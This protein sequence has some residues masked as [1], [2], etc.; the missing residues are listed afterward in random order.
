MGAEDKRMADK[1]TWTILLYLSTDNSL[2]EEGVYALKE[3]KKVGAKDVN[4]FAQFDPSGRGN[5]TRRFL[6]N[7]YDSTGK[8]KDT[9][10][11]QSLDET[12]M[13][14]PDTLRSFIMAAAIRFPATTNFMLILAGHGGGISEGFFLRDE[15][16][17]LSEIPSAFPLK[18]LKEQ[19]FA[20][21]DVITALGNR[22]I[23][24]LGLDSCMMSM[25]EVCYEIRDCEKL[26]YVVASEGFSLDAGWPYE[27]LVS[28]IKDDNNIEPLALAKAIVQEHAAFYADYHLGGLSTDLSVVKL[29]GIADL[30]KKIGDLAEALSK[31]FYA[32]IDLED[33]GPDGTEVLT[34]DLRDRKKEER[35][36]YKLDGRPF[37][38][39]IILAHWAAQSYN[40][41]QSIDLNDFCLM[42]QKRSHYFE[43]KEAPDSIYKRCEAVQRAI[44]NAVAITCD[45]GAAF[46]FSQGVSISLP[47]SR[48][49]LPP[50]YPT[51]RFSREVPGWLKF[52]ADYADA[53]QRLP[54]ARPH[55][56]E[57]RSTPPYSRGPEGRTLSMRNPP[58]Q[59]VEH[60]CEANATEPKR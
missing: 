19:V 21:E 45:E 54:R 17:P 2:S 11:F 16:R 36:F 55:I 25:V 3:I 37:Q 29:E 43:D 5:K 15:E 32:E 28:R 38:D 42:L 7:S 40:G 10:I 48:V 8:L 50:N 41:E 13:S 22:K 20:N 1:K 39:S 24:I 27:R 23:D 33:N 46:Q 52:I 9:D 18:D 49:N 53:T 51:L 31:K 12:D 30:A 44:L 59:F 60:D 14:K 35:L 6:I 4:V 47:W 57:F 56:V 26:Q 58:T 34:G